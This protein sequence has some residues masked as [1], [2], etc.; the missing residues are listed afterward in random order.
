MADMINYVLSPFEEK[1]NPG[2]PTGLK[3]YLQAT[4]EID[5]EADKLDISVSNAKDIIDDF[6]SLDNKYG[7]V[8]FAFI[9][10]TGSGAKNIFRQVEQIQ[11]ADIQHQSDGYFVLTGIVNIVNSLPNLLVVSALLN[12]S[13]SAQEVQNFYDRACSDMIAKE[14]EG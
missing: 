9:V 1:I 12:L 4:K 3:L 14:I 10:Q 13:T 5:K 6:L 11:F 7:I 8:R 2:D